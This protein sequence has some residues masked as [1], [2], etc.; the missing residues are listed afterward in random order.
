MLII[1]VQRTPKFVVGIP[2][3]NDWDDAGVLVP[4]AKVFASPE[5]AATAL[6]WKGVVPIATALKSLLVIWLFDCA[7]YLLASPFA[8]VDAVGSMDRVPPA[9]FTVARFRALVSVRV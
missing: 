6:V 3:P 9:R 4:N 7:I 8:A 5:A 2:D 1:P